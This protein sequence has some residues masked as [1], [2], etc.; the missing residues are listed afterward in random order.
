MNWIEI[1][2]WVLAALCAVAAAGLVFKFSV[3]RKSSSVVQKGNTAG[4][5]IVAGNKT[6]DSH[7]KR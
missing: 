4:G 6:T 7:N 5:D 1:G 2:K 3:N